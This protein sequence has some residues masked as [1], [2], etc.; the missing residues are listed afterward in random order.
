MA[1]LV[2]RLLQPHLVPRSGTH[3]VYLGRGP[4]RLAP[5]EVPK[6]T[7][8]E[9]IV[10]RDYTKRRIEHPARGSAVSAR[11]QQ[12]ARWYVGKRRLQPRHR[13]L[14]DFG[15]GLTAPHGVRRPRSATRRTQ[16][17][18]TPAPA[19]GSAPHRPKLISRKEPSRAGSR[20]DARASLHASA[21][22]SARRDGAASTEPLPRACNH[23]S[24]EDHDP[25]RL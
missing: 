13:A 20:P 5:E 6:L 3:G 23:P 19:R 22:D 12:P 15:D 8:L 17:G 24:R 18:T 7:N 14:P 11:H 4:T 1:L 9:P 16:R 21:T 2:Q 25:S 10:A